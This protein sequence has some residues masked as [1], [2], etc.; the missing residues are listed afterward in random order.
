VLSNEISGTV[1]VFQ[2]R[3]RP[4]QQRAKS[5]WKRSTIRT[6]HVP[7]VDLNGQTIFEGGISGLHYIPGTDKE[8]YAVGDRGPNAAAGS[9]PNATGTTLLFPKPDYAP[10]VTRFQSRKRRLGHPKRGTAS[11]SGRRH[12][13]ACPCLPAP[14]T[15]GETAWADTTPVVLTPDV[16]GMDSEGIVEDNEGNLWFCEEY[17]ASVWKV[18]KTTLEV[19]KRYTPF[20]TQ[21]EDAP[22][23]AAV[24]KRRANRGFEG[25]AYTPNGKIYAFVQSPADNPNVDGRQHRPPVAYGGN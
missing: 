13:P 12:R 21:A 19:I 4:G 2:I 17:G 7:I 23:P 8:F 24:G 9:H 22:L 20:P 3:P 1:S 11:P 5:R 6:Y 18:N 10:K 16:W 15:T 14:A 25:V